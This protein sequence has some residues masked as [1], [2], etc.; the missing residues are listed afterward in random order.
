MKLIEADRERM[1]L[2]GNLETTFFKALIEQ[3]KAI[4]IPIQNLEFIFDPVT[5][6]VNSP[7]RR[8]LVK[9]AIHKKTQAVDGF[10]H[11]R[12]HRAQK[13]FHGVGLHQHSSALLKENS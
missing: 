1:P 6:N 11:I 9:I 4:A 10:P 3:T 7:A 2:L 8:V 13:D 5:K 12:W